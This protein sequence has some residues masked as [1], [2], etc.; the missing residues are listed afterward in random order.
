MSVILKKLSSVVAQE[1]SSAWGVKDDLKKLKETLDM[2]VAVT[3]DAENKQ[4]NDAAVRL[5]LRKLKEVAYDADD[6]L[7]EFLYETMRRREMNIHKRGKVRDLISSANPLSFQFKMA[8][9]I[10]DV[11][12][13]L[14]KIARDKVRFQLEPTSSIDFA[15][16]QS[17][18]QR[19]RLTSSF[20]DDSKI[21]GREDDKSKITKMLMMTD[22]SSS[23]SSGSYSQQEKVSVISLLGMGGLGKTAL[24]Q[25]VFKDDSIEKHFEPRMWVCVSRD[26][27]VYKILT[28]IIESITKRK[29][30]DASNVEVLVSQVHENLSGK[31]YL[32]VLDDL[33]NE[34]AEDW[35][36]LKDL[37][38]VGAQGSKIL[39]T[40]RSHKVASV[41]MGIIPPYELSF[42]N[43]GECWSIIKSRAFSPGG[44]SETQNMSDIGKQIAKKSAG[45]PLVAKFLGSLMHSKKSEDDWSSIRDNDSLNDILNANKNH[46]NVI[47]VLKLSYDNLPSHLKQCFT[48]CSMFPKDW[49]INRETLIRLW[50][51]EGFLQSSVNSRGGK[52]SAEDIGN[53]YFESLLWNSFFQDVKGNELGDIK[54]CKMHDLVHDLALS[55][56]DS[57]EIITVNAT[58]ADVSEV[59]RLQLV[60]NEATSEMLA[61]ALSSSNKLRT[62]FALNSKG[63][64]KIKDFVTSKCLR[65]LCLIGLY[66]LEIPSSVAAFKHL[67]YLDLSGSTIGEGYDGYVNCLYNLETLVLRKC[68]SVW[69]VLKDIGSLKN[70]RHI[71][72]S[73]SDIKVLPDSVVSLSNLQTLDLSECLSFESLPI[74]IGSLQNLRYLN[75]RD[76][77]ITKLPESITS[78]SS[79]SEV[80]FTYCKLLE[81]LPSDFG[82]L[83][84]LRALYLVGTG[85][86][87][88]PESCVTKLC[89]LE[90]VDLGWNCELPKEVKNWPK[91]RSLEYN[92]N[93]D[94]TPR[95]ID[96]LTC[97]ESL[98]YM[99]RKEDVLKPDDSGIEE[100]GDLSALQELHIRNL[101]NVKGR[102]D[103]ERANLK[104]KKNVHHLKLF[105]S[106]IREPGCPSEDG[107]DERSNSRSVS[108]S[109]VLEGLQP[110]PNLKE[111]QLFGF[112]GSWLPKWM[113]GGIKSCIPNLVELYF[114]ECGNCNQLPALGLLPCLKVLWMSGM[115]TVKRLGN[116]FY[117]EEMGGEDGSSYTMKK[118][119][120][121][122]VISFPSLTKLRIQS[123]NNLEEWIS[124]PPPCKPF[125]CLEELSIGY[126]KRLK[127]TPSH[128]PSLKELELE[129]ISDK[130]LISMANRGLTSFRSLTIRN[131]PELIIFPQ[132][133]LLHNYHLQ[134][135]AIL[136]CD[137]FQGFHL[138][139]AEALSCPEGNYTSNIRFLELFACPAVTF[140]P[141]LKFWTSI[142]K[143]SLK[144]SG[145]VNGVFKIDPPQGQ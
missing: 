15:H 22:A 140:L 124:P 11:N 72:L 114:Y 60:S 47:Q 21:I 24:A 26:F 71:Y 82:A 32:L 1:I 130:N 117:F 17:S 62:I 18:E 132:S 78:I 3:S 123:M 86:K 49:E 35:E 37:L 57:R 88:L 42:L 40:T 16:D 43:P 54:T 120:P 6:V 41:V 135:L 12:K 139:E 23:V 50:M 34:N 8:H 77:L 45:L 105:W 126:C 96:R 38:V 53:D 87:L 29:C 89:H 108:D 27:D 91:L 100:L 111:L 20:V 118:A 39:V 30:D 145:R 7:D 125:P 58:E 10:R 28:N 106:L 13:T 14:D 116:E 133:L 128:F 76:S 143:I 131:S 104:K 93:K 83:T 144:D 4:I 46:S 19:N 2:I 64:F 129:G 9:K 66:T 44:A 110:H 122:T 68:I 141:I 70:L 52:K 109:M 119:N 138:N 92:R 81:A 112:Y 85:V 94:E 113:G 67:R 95:G 115:K 51:A 74:N 56:V 55:V 61:K 75:I 36:K 99:V 136:C 80:Y 25:L 134:S 84:R 59:R 101:E 97:L 5:W 103:A 98:R 142:R 102:V 137:K 121:T 107:D 90:A 79:L 31:K 33:W 63:D 127:T 69:K 73:H 65:V 48:Y